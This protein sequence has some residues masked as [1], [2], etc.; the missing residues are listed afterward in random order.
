MFE[1]SWVWLY[2]DHTSERGIWGGWVFL[3]VFLFLPFVGRRRQ[4]KKKSSMTHQGT[5][6]LSV[7]IRQ[8]IHFPLHTIY[9]Y[10]KDLACT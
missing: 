6:L 2:L 4:G 8:A 10:G 7:F 9:L 1:N 3:C 5:D